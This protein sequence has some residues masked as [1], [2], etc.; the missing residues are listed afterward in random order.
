MFPAPHKKDL[1]GMQQKK[2]ILVTKENTFSS[3]TSRV[4]YF[5]FVTP[6]S[7]SHI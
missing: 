1:K 6:N 2:K 4:A 5:I 7:L 3:V